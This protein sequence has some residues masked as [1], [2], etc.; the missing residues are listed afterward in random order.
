LASRGDEMQIE[1][2]LTAIAADLVVADV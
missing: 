1:T 2:R